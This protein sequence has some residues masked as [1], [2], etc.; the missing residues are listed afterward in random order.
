MTEDQRAGQRELRISLGSDKD[1]ASAIEREKELI[2]NTS[3]ELLESKEYFEIYPNTLPNMVANGVVVTL[4][5]ELKPVFK[6]VDT[7]AAEFESHTPYFY[8]TAGSESDTV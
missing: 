4:S 2:N 5:R 8:A 1:M 3:V 7:C 6:M